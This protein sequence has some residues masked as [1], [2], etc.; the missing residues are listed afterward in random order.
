[1][2]TASIVPA[3]EP[4][5]DRYRRRFST[6]F[7]RPRPGRGTRTHERSTT[8]VHPRPTTTTAP[9][10]PARPSV[11]AAHQP[12]DLPPIIF[13]AVTS[14]AQPTNTTVSQIPFV[15]LGSETVGGNCPARPT[16]GSRPSRSS[17][18]FVNEL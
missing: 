16:S 2:I 12:A 13:L 3:V 7:Q 15:T 1:M 8:S 17:A 10:R 6:W 5:L 4:V 9:D 18:A 14:R 11:P